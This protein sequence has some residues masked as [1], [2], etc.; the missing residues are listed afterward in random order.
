M[1]SGKI[2]ISFSWLYTR[3]D[4]LSQS[5]ARVYAI[6]AEKEKE[7]GTVCLIFA[8]AASVFRKRSRISVA[9][10]TIFHFSNIYVVH[11]IELEIAQNGNP[12]VRYI[13]SGF[14]Y[15]VCISL[16]FPISRY[17]C[18]LFS[19]HTYTSSDIKFQKS[20]NFI[21]AKWKWVI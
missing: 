21:R 1:K 9:I 14:V 7:I 13:D 10:Y 18:M 6:H 11:W 20:I 16:S 3:I 5:T 4:P 2:I 17:F 15:F 19:K 12:S 8:L